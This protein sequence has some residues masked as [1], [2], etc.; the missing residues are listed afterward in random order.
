MFYHKLFN[1]P[2][3]EGEPEVGDKQ[4]QLRILCNRFHSFAPDNWS[5]YL[6]HVADILANDV[7]V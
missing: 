5:E 4:E 7:D 2:Y 6:K 1:V 3:Q